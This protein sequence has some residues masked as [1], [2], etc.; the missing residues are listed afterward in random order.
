[1]QFAV[2]AVEL[3]GN[4]GWKRRLGVDVQRLDKEVG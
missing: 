4:V 3:D 2:V 1:M